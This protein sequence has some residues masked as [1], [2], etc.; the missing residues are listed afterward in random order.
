M[1]V[2]PLVL[3]GTLAAVGGQASAP[4]F[5]SEPAAA[6]DH[7]IVPPGKDPYANVFRVIQEKRAM[8]Q[9]LK[10][11]QSKTAETRVVCGMV[12]VPMTPDADPKM[13][14]QPLEKTKTEYKIRKIEPRLCNE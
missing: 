12:V 10:T 4:R 1:N 11:Q 3:V 6:Q 8:Q 9:L 13:L 2:I 5:S 14:V 7:S